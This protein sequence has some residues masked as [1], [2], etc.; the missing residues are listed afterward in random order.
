MI[1]AVDDSEILIGC[2][3]HTILAAKDIKC[4]WFDEKDHRGI[5][6]LQ[7]RDNKSNGGEGGILLP[8]FLASADE[9]YTSVIIRCC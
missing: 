3:P 9:S 7:A 2:K 4:A 5:S 8:P 1:A 6:S